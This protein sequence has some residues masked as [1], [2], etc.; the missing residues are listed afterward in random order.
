MTGFQPVDGSSILLA[1]TANRKVVRK[2]G[3]SVVAVRSE[4]RCGTPF[5]KNRSPIELDWEHSELIQPIGVLKL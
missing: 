4:E 1:R 5:V 2:D 3:F